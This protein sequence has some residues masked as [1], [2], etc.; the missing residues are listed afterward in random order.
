VVQREAIS[1][2]ER[3]EVVKVSDKKQ[4]GDGKFA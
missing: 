2:F 1:R 4:E 3:D